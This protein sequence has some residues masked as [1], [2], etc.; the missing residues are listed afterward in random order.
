M[1][2]AVDGTVSVPEVPMYASTVPPIV[3]SVSSPL[4]PNAPPPA[5]TDVA[6][7]SPVACTAEFEVT[8]TP[9]WATVTGALM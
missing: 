4:P 1:T 6:T 3:V 7:A 8:W 5:A 9:P 2:L